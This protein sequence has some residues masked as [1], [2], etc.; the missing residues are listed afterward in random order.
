MNWHEMTKLK[1]TTLG[2]QYTD[3]SY[4]ETHLF[5]IHL[6]DKYFMENLIQGV[7]VWGLSLYLIYILGSNNTV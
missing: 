7:L 4:I 6:V 5:F 2:S 1:S 3:C